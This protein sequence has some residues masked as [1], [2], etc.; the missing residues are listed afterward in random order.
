MP[1]RYGMRDAIQRVAESFIYLNQRQ[2]A[3]KK[4]WDAGLKHEPVPNPG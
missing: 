1:I 3:L 4:Q 2:Q